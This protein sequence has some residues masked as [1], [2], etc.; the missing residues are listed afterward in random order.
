MAYDEGLAERV[1]DL[2]GGR[3]VEK[4]MFG[5]VAFM[6][7][8]NMSVGIMGDGLL[9]RVAAGDNDALLAEPGVTQPAM[10]GRTMKGWLLVDGDAV[11]EDA[12]L[13]DWVSR[14][15]TYASSLPPK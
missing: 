11:A 7:D 10:G 4:K 1:R 9:V 6:L 14:G 13:Q 3:V 2:L 15:T 12:A 8:G 5:G